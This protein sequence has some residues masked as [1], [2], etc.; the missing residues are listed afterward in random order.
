M[1]TTSAEKP[2]GLYQNFWRAALVDE[3][4]GK[5]GGHLTAVDV[6]ECYRS[7]V[8]P[9]FVGKASHALNVCFGSTGDRYTEECFR[10][11][12]QEDRL[13]DIRNAINHGDIDAENPKE[14]VRVDARLSRLWMIVWRMFGRFIPFPTP[15]DPQEAP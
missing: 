6:Q 4:V 2:D 10:L 15:A 9:G 14:L 5:R 8:N 12:P 3:F 1:P 13:Y 11:S 7:I